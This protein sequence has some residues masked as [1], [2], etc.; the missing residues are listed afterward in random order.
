MLDRAMPELSTQSGLKTL[1]VGLG[2]TGL[3]CARY[4]AA[5]GVAVAVTDSRV[6]P[7]GLAALRDELPD[8]AVFLGGFSEEALNG[9][10]QLV[11]SPGVAPGAGFVAAARTRGLPVLSDIEIFARAVDTPMAAITGSNGKSTVTALLGHMAE[12][13]GRCVRIGGN[14]GTPALDLL[15]VAGVELIVLELSSFQLELTDS[16]APA[17][18]TVLNVTP[19]HLDRH[20]DMDAYAAAKARIFHRAEVAVIN[21]DDARIVAMPAPGQTVVSFG[22]NSPPTAADF[23][24]REHRGE[25]WLARGRERILPAAAVGI[26][27]G[28]NLANALAALALGTALDLDAAAMAEALGKFRGLPHRMARVADINGVRWYDDSKATNVG[29]TVAA[30]QGLTGPLVVIAGGDGKN[31]DFAPLAAAFKGKVRATVLLGKDAARLAGALEG[32][33]SCL[34]VATMEAAVAAAERLA[35]P[36]DTVLLSPACSS[37]DM[38]ENFEAR[39]RAFATA[40]R[41]LADGG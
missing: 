21:R 13:A 6:H 17:A 2:K 1:V 15:P 31:A 11:V 27:G 26:R 8:V 23:G 30:V 36:G 35:R 41:A 38:F 5:R 7:P 25:V 10:N 20:A 33:V 3:S 4:L 14:F 39:G 16:L 12:T 28:H 19:D 32:C 34:D 37:L 24:V 22:L 29:A 40:V 9:A 18:A